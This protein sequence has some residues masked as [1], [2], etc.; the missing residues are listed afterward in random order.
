MTGL[1][2][3]RG[4]DIG[5]EFDQLQPTT[6]RPVRVCLWRRSEETATR[7]RSPL[8]DTVLHTSVNSLTIDI[9]HTWFLGTHQRFLGWLV[10][11]ARG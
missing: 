6:A 3:G 1:S 9:L 11:N 2:L 5:D 8:L 10:E 4:Q 7:H